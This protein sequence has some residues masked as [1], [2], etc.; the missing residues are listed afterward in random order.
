[1]IDARQK[2]IQ[3]IYSTLTRK[4][5]T[6]AHNFAFDSKYENRSEYPLASTNL[7]HLV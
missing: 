5:A 6:R 3:T 7:A 2:T 1:M 4:N